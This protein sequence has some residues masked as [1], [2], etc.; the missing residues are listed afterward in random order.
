MSDPIIKKLAVRPVLHK[1]YCP[2]CDK[3]LERSP[4]VLTTY[5]AQYQYFCPEC[6]YGYT[7]FE[8]YP[9]IDWEE[10]ADE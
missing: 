8:Q 2:D 6:D 7:A 1:A 5:P 10:I 4:V 3:E 9:K